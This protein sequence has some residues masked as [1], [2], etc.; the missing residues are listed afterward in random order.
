MK[1]KVCDKSLKILCPQPEQEKPQAVQLDMDAA[2]H[3]LLSAMPMLDK[4]KARELAKRIVGA[5]L[6]A[7]KPLV[8]EPA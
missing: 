1:Q 6:S 8:H 7:N 2:V 4:D 3:A 5:A